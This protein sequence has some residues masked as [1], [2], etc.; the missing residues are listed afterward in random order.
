MSQK[1]GYKY[2]DHSPAAGGIPGRLG[3]PVSP[4]VRQGRVSLLQC[5]QG[6]I[7][8]GEWSGAQWEYVGGGRRALTGTPHLSALETRL[9]HPCVPWIT[10]LRPAAH[11]SCLRA[12]STNASPSKSCKDLGPGC[13]SPVC[14]SSISPASSVSRVWIIWPG[15]VAHSTSV[16]P[17]STRGTW[18]HLLF[19][20]FPTPTN[21]SLCLPFSPHDWPWPPASGLD[22]P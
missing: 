6:A 16:S 20:L 7:L 19:Y 14:A 11:F 13:H 21:P 2:G 12:S 17:Q 22:F 15:G 8:A 9:S 10:S 3:T 5:V 1:E 18:Q 4:Y